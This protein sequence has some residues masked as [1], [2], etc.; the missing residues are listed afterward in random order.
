MNFRN[1]KKAGTNYTNILY[2]CLFFVFTSACSGQG[3]PGKAQTGLEVRTVSITKASGGTVTVEAEIAQ[4]EEQRTT[5]LM[6]RTTLENGKGMFFM[7]EEDE[8]LA[9]WMKNTLIPLSIAYISY[10]GTI[11]DIRDMYPKDTSSVRSSRSVRYALEVP[12]GWFTQAGIKAGDRVSL[13]Q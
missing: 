8:V 2:I 3:Y 6:F 4:T 1:P 7:F 10:D 9:F 11:T 13:P 12:Q 5:G